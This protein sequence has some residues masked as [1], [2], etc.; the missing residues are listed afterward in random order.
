M[1]FGIGEINTQGLIWIVATHTKCI[2]LVLGS[3]DTFIRDMEIILPQQTQMMMPSDGMIQLTTISCGVTH[4]SWIMKTEKD[5]DMG[6]YT[7][8]S[9]WIL[10]TT[11][12]WCLRS[13]MWIY[14]AWCSLPKFICWMNQNNQR[15]QKKKKTVSYTMCGNT[16]LPVIQKAHMPNLLPLIAT[17][18]MK[19]NLAYVPFDNWK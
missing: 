9:K 16:L 14:Y 17:G 8:L 7:L 5:Q 11:K 10:M 15:L 13:H 1:A 6:V 18:T 4:Q 12:F 3:Q 19:A 2:L